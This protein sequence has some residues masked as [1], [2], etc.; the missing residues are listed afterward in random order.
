M[1]NIRRKITTEEKIAI[2]LTDVVSDLRLDLD[3]TGRYLAGLAPNV[4][5]RRLSEIVEAA[6]YER[7]RM[8]D[9]QHIDTLFD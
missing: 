3:M 7:E 8:Y 2:K 9:R 1:M 5:F 4:S 6:E